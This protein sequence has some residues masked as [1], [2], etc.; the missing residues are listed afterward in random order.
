MAPAP[1]RIAALDGLRAFAVTGVVLLHSG[2]GTWGWVGVDVFFVLSGYLIT[3]ILLDARAAGG[4]G[5]RT[6]ARPFYWRRAVRI[7][8][9]AMI[10]LIVAFWVVPVAHHVAPSALRPW[11]WGRVPLDQQVWWWA[12]ASNW[13][14][15]DRALGAWAMTHYWSLSVEEQFY[16]VWP[17][18]VLA[19][20]RRRLVQVASALLLA[21]PILRLL[22]A[23]TVSAGQLPPP[24]GSAYEYVTVLRMD[25][26]LAGALVALVAPDAAALTRWA[27]RAVWITL[28]GLL[29]ALAAIRDPAPLGWGYVAKFSGLALAFGG[30]LLLLLAAPRS[31]PARALTH[32]ALGGLGMI[33]Y[34][35]YV[36]HAP[37]A[38]QLRAHGLSGPVAA[39]I[40]L[41]LS[42][43][44]AALSWRWLELPFLAHKERYAMPRNPSLA[45]AARCCV[46]RPE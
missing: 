35:V 8:P 2:V 10:A 9:L 33:S 42:V 3:G 13:W 16:F 12:Y 11:L 34:G 22:V 36:L 19:C 14:T 18:V 43:G 17:W 24:V 41:V 45:A 39:A 28:V 21:A 4:L 23:L 32:P 26:L 25:G 7:L 31:G 15:R 40:T 6:Y 38:M 30:G 20:S 46:A 29:L 27:R 5:W 44:L 37:I 1:R